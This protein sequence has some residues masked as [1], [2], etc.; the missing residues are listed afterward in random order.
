MK[1]VWVVTADSWN[2]EYSSTSVVGVYDEETA[3]RIVREN[4][5]ITKRSPYGT[6]YD[7][8]EFIY[9]E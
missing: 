4:N 8:E 3:R 2:G 6:T 9:N 1:K 7:Y 5:E